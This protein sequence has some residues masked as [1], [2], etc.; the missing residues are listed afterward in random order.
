[1][2]RYTVI[3]D[4]D[5]EAHAYSAVVPALSGCATQGRTREEALANA[6][7]AVEL[8]VEVLQERGQAIP[9]DV[10]T[11]QVQIAA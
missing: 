1:V 11:G 5:E 6:R 9:P 2:R 10:E 4:W 3:L 7:E 8:Y